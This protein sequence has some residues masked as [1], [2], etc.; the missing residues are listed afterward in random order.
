MPTSALT[1]ANVTATISEA[2]EK[3]REA[4]NQDLAGRLILA[5]AS[6]SIGNDSAVVQALVSALVH[7]CR[8]ASAILQAT[9]AVMTTE[10]KNDLAKRVDERGFIGKEG[11]TTRH[12]DRN[13]V[14]ARA[15]CFLY[16]TN[17]PGVLH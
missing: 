16:V 3:L 11:G 2:A 6:V 14:V 5:G 15:E 13:E 12:W 17:K 9:L 4:G 10:Q 8:A 7:E 1:P